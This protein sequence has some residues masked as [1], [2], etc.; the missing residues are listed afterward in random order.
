[1]PYTQQDHDERCQEIARRIEQAH[2][3]WLIIWGLH[4]R[5]FW[6]YPCLAVPP[7]TVVHEPDPEALVSEMKRVESAVNRLHEAGADPGN[8]AGRHG[9]SRAGTSPAAGDRLSRHL[10]QNPARCREGG[11]PAAGADYGHPA[12]GAMA[13]SLPGI[14]VSVGVA[15]RFVGDAVSGCPR[16]DDLILAVSELASNAV[17]W[18]ASGQDGTFTI[19]VR[20]A[21]RWARIEVTDLGPAALTTASSNGWGLGIVAQITDRTGTTISQAGART[22]WAEVTWP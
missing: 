19:R 17:A 16:I 4:S 2:P 15:R 8:H 7:G 13:I 9:Q 5:E 10:A 22:A 3:C 21:P 18:S 1:M 12:R 14:P 20:T 6:A 11:W